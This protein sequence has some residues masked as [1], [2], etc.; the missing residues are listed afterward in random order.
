MRA[1]RVSQKCLILHSWRILNGYLFNRIWDMCDIFKRETGEAKFS[2][3][4]RTKRIRR[5]KLNVSGLYSSSI[6]PFEAR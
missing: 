4:K 2:V 6:L 1:W 5:K 3:V